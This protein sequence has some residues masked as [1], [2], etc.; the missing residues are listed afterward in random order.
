[1]MLCGTVL[2]T[3][4]SQVSTIMVPYSS[5]GLTERWDKGRTKV[6]KSRGEEGREDQENERG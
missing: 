5:D 6:R 3:R 1:M 2:L 4:A